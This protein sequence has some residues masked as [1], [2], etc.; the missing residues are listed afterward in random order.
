VS[1]QVEEAQASFEFDCAHAAIRA[2]WRLDADGRFS[3]KGVFV[4]EH[5]GPVRKGED[6]D[7]RPALFKGRLQ[8]DRLEF[9]IEL[10]EE[11]QTAG[12]YVVTLGGRP[13]IFKCK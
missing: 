8:G 3:V 6:E 10:T 1:I 5:G 12:S 9:E 13:R 7:E 2:P 4:R 11:K